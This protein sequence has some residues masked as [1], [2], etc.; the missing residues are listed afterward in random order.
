VEIKSRR[1]RRSKFQNVDGVQPSA[2]PETPQREE[3]HSG[4]N[5]DAAEKREV[6]N[7]VQSIPEIF[8]PEDVKWCFDVYVGI[9]C[10]AYSIILKTDFD[11]LK[12]ELE[13]SKEHKDM[14]AVPLAKILSKT[15][16]ASWA[17]LKNEFQL[18]GMLGIYTVT[19][20]K[21]AQAVAKAELEKKQNAERTQP[22]APM[23]KRADAHVPA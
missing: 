3:L 19:S 5:K 8:T 21:R 20:F 17:G 15:V 12:N 16:P 6:L 23:H 7:A 18:I 10:F 9:L 2:F 22:V 11:A 4:I 13:I 14:M 1:G